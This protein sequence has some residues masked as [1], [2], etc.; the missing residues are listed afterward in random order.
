MMKHVFYFAMLLFS[1]W[2][3]S[4]QKQPY[5]MSQELRFKMETRRYELIGV[6]EEYT[7]YIYSLQYPKYDTSMLSYYSHGQLD[8]TRNYSGNG[9]LT[10]KADY[11]NHGLKQDTI[12]MEYVTFSPYTGDTTGYFIHYIDKNGVKWSKQYAY[13][14]QF[15]ITKKPGLMY[16]SKQ[17]FFRRSET[18]QFTDPTYREAQ[19]YDSA[20]Y[21]V[22]AAET[23]LFVQYY[24]SGK[25]MMCGKNARWEYCMAHKGAYPVYP[26]YGKTGVWTYYSY[27]DGTKS[28]EEYYDGEGVLTE[29]RT[30][31]PSGSIESRMNYS[32]AFSSLRPPAAEGIDIANK[33]SCK[34][35]LTKWYNTGILSNEVI[36]TP[37]G[38]VV[39][40]AF[41][42]NGIPMNFKMY[43]AQRQPR[44]IHRK[45]DEHGTPIQFVNYSVETNDTLCF[46]GEGGK[47]L[48][49]NKRNKWE[50]MNWNSLPFG[51][52]YSSVEQTMI[53]LN[54]LTAQH[55]EFY[56]NGQIKLDIHLQTGKLH[57]AYAE[58]D[59]SGVQ[60]VE[61]FYITDIRNGHW[62]E[63]YPN[64]QK[65]KDYYYSHG[66]K[67]GK[68]T[69]YYSFGTVRWENTYTNGIAGKAVAFSEN[70]TPLSA[71]SYFDAFYPKDCMNRQAVML[72]PAGLYYYMSDP[73]TDKKEVTLADSSL[74]S[75]ELKT[76]AALLAMGRNAD[77][78]GD[79]DITYS[80]K[81]FDLY[82]SSFVMSAGL[83]NDSTRAIMNSFF[84]RHGIHIDKIELMEVPILGLEKEYKVSY[85]AT[86]ILNNTV[87]LDSLEQLCI[88]NSAD[89][90]NG[91][92]LSLHA[93]IPASPAFGHGF[94]SS[95]ISE[96]G[97]TVFLV[98]RNNQSQAYGFAYSATRYVIYDDYTVDFLSEE[99]Q[100]H[101]LRYWPITEITSIY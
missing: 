19:R 2:S 83:H 82:H 93:N 40:Y 3:L 81:E 77:F 87:I 70:G 95:M 17:R 94:R 8:W 21:H 63:W 92:F 9:K 61:G 43:N 53:F 30:F 38:D 39:E 33:D 62:R 52:S 4:A 60:T 58:W 22:N 35:A 44:G 27:V 71:T 96:N 54:Q 68:C 7:G 46:K 6:D 13:Y 31:Y 16:I 90:R 79:P 100:Q 73:N 5:H 42:T 23:G 37:K 32:A 47:I 48:S 45:W 55:Q 56:A 74:L 20:G 65:K 75:F 24:E 28:K 34:V 85:S 78:C 84:A 25:V 41:H 50:K 86:E 51:Q 29:S 76:V 72:R 10:L 80:S 67:N 36:V 66:I 15:D 49:L 59:S 88:H 101:Q 91:Y 12:C 64:G 69:D 18:R 57:G 97:Y 11:Y 26:S 1:V 98:E 14:G 99:T 89:G